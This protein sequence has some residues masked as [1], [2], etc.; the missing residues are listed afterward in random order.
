MTQASQSLTGWGRGPG[1]LGRVIT[2]GPADDLGRVLA[3]TSGTVTVRAAGGA[4]GDA[5]VPAQDDGAVL[6]VSARD[7]VVDLDIAA[8]RAVV[9]SGLSLGRLQDAVAPHGWSVP[10]LPGTG[11]VT[12]GGA[13]ASD[14]HGK[15]Q[16]GAGT[17]GRHV[18]WLTLAAPDGTVR[19][20][21]PTEDRDGF[22]ATT[23]G[24]GL[25]GVI[26]L[27]AVQLTPLTSPWLRRTRERTSDLASTVA[28]M[29]VVARR[30]QDD[31]RLHAVAWLDLT[32]PVRSAGRGV[33][34]VCRPAA[35]DELPDGLS[36]SDPSPG[37]STRPMR[38]VRSLPG[39]GVTWRPVLRGAAAARWHAARPTMASHLTLD[40]ALLPLDAVAWWPAA[41]GA[42][43][44]VQYQLLLP[45]AAVDQ[46]PVVL[47]VLRRRRVPPALAVLKRFGPGAAAPLA[48]AVE[49]WS[50]AMDFPRRWAQLE[51]ALRELDEVVAGHGGRVYLTKDARLPA[52]QLARMYPRLPQWRRVRDRLDPAGRMTSSLAERTGLVAVRAQPPDDTGRR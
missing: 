45:V 1:R 5:A 50:L 31:E 28:A 36:A 3:G 14:V 30:Q 39:A 21:A 19:R 27:V 40:D 25:T 29:D 17:F 13:V 46:L 23:G 2:P 52:A 49:G 41:F 47:D 34:D 24:L 15:N 7:A 43:G 8:G 20:L 12:V 10:V 32:G 51:P 9:Q 6:D 11:R 42:R 26:D 37:R 4:Y 35:P 33:V 48:F 16:P 22:L 44:L 38:R 18:R